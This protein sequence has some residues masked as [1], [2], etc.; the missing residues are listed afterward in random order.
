M[1]FEFLKYLPLFEMRN[2]G[3]CYKVFEPLAWRL[4][5]DLERERGVVAP[6]CAACRSCFCWSMPAAMQE[7][8]HSTA[9]Q[10]WSA[11]HTQGQE[12]ILS[13][14]TPN[15]TQRVCVGKGDITLSCNNS[16]TQFPTIQLNLPKISASMLMKNFMPNSFK[17]QVYS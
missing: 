11:Q 13:L 6:S 16:L 5:G 17:S 4:P 14:S 10:I 8:T 15:K 3:Q 1:Y 9:Q 7:N 12:T 2:F